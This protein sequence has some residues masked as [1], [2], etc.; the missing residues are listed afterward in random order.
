MGSYH[1]DFGPEG[2]K[3]LFMWSYPGEFLKHPAGVQ[4]NT[5]FQILGARML[6]QLVAEGIREAGLSAL[7]IHLRQGD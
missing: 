1:F 6:S 3:E 5:H 2:C 7:I 4:D